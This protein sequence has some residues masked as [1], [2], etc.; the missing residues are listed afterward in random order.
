[1]G[2]PRGRPATIDRAA[3]RETALRLFEERGY[4][5]TTVDEIADAAR[6]SKQTLFR[7]FPSKAD[8]V[9]DDLDDGL[10]RAFRAVTADPEPQTL[11]QIVHRVFRTP[12]ELA[13]P[14]Q[15]TSLRR[16]LRLVGA[17]PALMRHTTLDTLHE[18]MT[19]AVG[20]ATGLSAPPEL[21]ARTLVAAGLSAM[22]W[23][24]EHDDVDSP[25]HVLALT[26]RSLAEAAP[27]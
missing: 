12:A 27:A 9:W 13:D 16:R 11:A 24:A 18:R 10:D 2:K 22:I 4:E 20:R 1:M 3:V 8:L 14:A 25:A 23:W 17:T 21:V 6:I 7:L 19:A 5:Q 26:L 15:V